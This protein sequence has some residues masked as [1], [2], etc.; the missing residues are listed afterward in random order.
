M[1]SP[2]QMSWKY[3]STP[4]DWAGSRSYVL[5]AGSSL[6]AH[7]A[8]R[9][10]RFSIDGRSRTLLH[11]FDWAAE[12][13]A[14]G[15]GA[16]LLRRITSLADGLVILGGSPATRAMVR[17][18]GFRSLPEVARYGVPAQAP[19]SPVGEAYALEPPG[20]AID[21]SLLHRASS[22]EIIV[23]ERS[24]EAVRE[25]L[26]C[27]V[28]E[29]EYRVVSRRGRPI[30]FFLLAAAPGQARIVEAW[31]ISTELPDWVALL[32]L[33]RERAAERAGLLEVV[34]LAS[35]ELE[36]QALLRAGFSRCGTLPLHLL[37]AADVVSGQARIRFQ[38]MD[39]D[40]A[41]LHHGTPERW[42]PWVP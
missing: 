12:P 28:L 36:Q 17:P 15:S 9:P 40:I 3:W 37:A 29:T 38:M 5:A 39:G 33:A 10:L 21:P 13:A 22:S 4:I 14:L 8:V 30:G 27:P 26:R 2:E 11:L 42:S 35:V 25:L 24:A 23:F 1:F 41:F 7:A 16:A 19:Q 34:C 6:L 32:Q 20:T 31:S 18:L